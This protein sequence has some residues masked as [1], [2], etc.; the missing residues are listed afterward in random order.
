M[1]YPHVPVLASEVVH[2]FSECQCRYVVD[3]TLGAGGHAELLLQAHPEIELFIGID[4]DP[5]AL[6]IATERLA[7]WK[8]KLCLL[9]G[10]F[11]QLESHLKAVGVDKVQAILLDL[12]VSSMQLDQA[13]KGFSFMREGPLDMRMDPE[14]PVNAF[15]VVNSYSETE[16]GRIF[17]LYAEEKQWRAIAKLLV[18]EREKAEIKT[19]TQLSEVLMPLL[20]WK[21][22]RGI[23]PMTLVFQGLRIYVNRELE[24]LENVLPKVIDHLTPGGRAGIISFHSG[25]DRIVKK[26]LQHAASDKHDTEG[27]GRGL[28]LDKTPTVRIVTRKAVSATEEEINLNPRS[29][30]A[31]LRV[32]EKI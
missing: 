12:G 3:G 22:S 5:T 1:I 32:M 30:S 4:Q 17:K 29:R 27:N 2:Y 23:N 13:E 9:R 26:A 25:E 28:F 19:T 24:V 7:P 31:K 20:G 6:A 14:G 11:S 16:L 21:R 15:E 18:Q 8:E 10:N